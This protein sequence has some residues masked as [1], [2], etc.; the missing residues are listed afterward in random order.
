M[1]SSSFLLFFSSSFLLFFFSSFLFMLLVEIN[2]FSRVWGSL[3]FSSLLLSFFL[4]ETPETLLPRLKNKR[5]KERRERREEREEREEKREARERERRD[6]FG[7]KQR[8]FESQIEER[9][10]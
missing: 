3:L 6:C 5:E 8:I 7:E 2:F 9:E 4:F 1:F 10:F